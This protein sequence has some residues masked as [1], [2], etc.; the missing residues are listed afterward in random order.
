MWSIF[1]YFFQQSHHDIQV[2]LHYAAMYGHADVAT[3]LI[4]ESVGAI[5]FHDLLKKLDGCDWSC[6]WRVKLNGFSFGKVCEYW[7]WMNEDDVFVL[8]GFQIHCTLNLNDKYSNISDISDTS[9][10]CSVERT[11]RS[12]ED[13]HE[14]R[15]WLQNEWCEFEKKFFSFFFSFMSHATFQ[16]P[17]NAATNVHAN[18]IRMLIKNGADV[19]K[20]DV[21]LIGCFESNV[22]WFRSSHRKWV[23][24]ESAAP[25]F[26]FCF[27]RDLVFEVQAL[28]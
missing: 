8:G 9:L 13:V 24:I 1:W 26:V 19:N 15:R 17:Q 16:I 28:D 14:E 11:W 22:Y 23:W 21:C 20:T 5:N 4:E 18:A 3:L 7:N 2:P 25:S 12:S 10:L 6:W 27:S